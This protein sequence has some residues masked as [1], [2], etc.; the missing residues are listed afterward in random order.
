MSDGSTAVSTP[1]RREA[2]LIFFSYCRVEPDR[3]VAL[4]L[5]ELL[6]QQFDV[7]IDQN[8][9]PGADW[10]AEIETTIAGASCVIVLISEHSKRSPHVRAE[11]ELAHT[12]Y[13]EARRPAIIPVSVNF[14]G[15]PGYPLSAYVS[16][17]QFAAWK[18]P[19]DT[20][21]LAEELVKA[22]RRA[23]ERSKRKRPSAPAEGAQSRGL[24]AWLSGRRSS[25]N[26]TKLIR[27]VRRDW[28]E[29]FLY[30]ALYRV[31]RV[32]LDLSP[33]D[34]K[35]LR[36]VDLYLRRPEEP[37][38]LLA[39]AASVASIFSEQNGQLLILGAPGAGKTT[40]LLELT[41]DLLEAA[42]D[43][44]TVP[45]P[46]P[47]NLSS[48]AN[49]KKSLRD[50][51]AYELNHL[52]DCPGKLAIRW[53]RGEK[54]IPMLD[55]LD[56]V[57]EADREACVAAINEYRKEVG[58]EIVV[59][60]RVAEYDALT[61]RL[62]IPGAVVINLLTKSQVEQY[63][64]GGDERSKAVLAAAREDDTIWEV[65]DTPLTLD[66]AVL[67]SSTSEPWYLPS[68]TV[69]ER[70]AALFLRYID[71]MLE[72]RAVERRFQ[73]EQFQHWLGWL[74]FALIKRNQTQ[75][76][77]EDLT[78]DY[79][80][81][82]RQHRIATALATL[83]VGVPVAVSLKLLGYSGSSDWLGV[84]T[85]YAWLSASVAAA[86]GAVL[87]LMF[88]ICIAC[89]LALRVLQDAISGDSARFQR[90]VTGLILLFIGI[91]TAFAL[92]LGLGATAFN[93]LA[94]FLLF[95]QGS[96]VGTGAFCALL[97]WAGMTFGPWRPVD[98]VRWSWRKATEHFRLHACLVIA[99]GLLSTLILGWR[100][101]AQGVIFGAFMSLI[102]MMITGLTPG[103]L[104][105]KVRPN[106]GMR[107]SARNGAIAAVAGF[108]YGSALFAILFREPQWWSGGVIVAIVLGLLR[109]WAFCAQHW[110][111]RLVLWRSGVA[112]LRYTQF[113]DASAERI[114][115]HR[116]G[117][118]YI[119]VHRM[120]MNC[121]AAIYSAAT[122]EPMVLPSASQA[123]D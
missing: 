9:E 122:S 46:V 31:A 43:D 91:T 23:V 42:E 33:V 48:W 47:F 44:T 75:L 113:L 37:A 41:E 26:R 92:A 117:G 1:E 93:S 58:G 59:T 62:I 53:I 77:L 14:E 27:R 16:P 115:L 40:L 87:G 55:G 101:L 85:I 104:K 80:K 52:Y 18:G 63:L 89:A 25:K 3:S 7:F 2:P 112:P 99:L 49:S 88:A 24:F 100:G 97:V 90:T 94:A 74:A 105:E 81:T 64:E 71:R 35:A 72:W 61:T 28:I 106:E 95:G 120:L 60:S 68:G 21:R 8:L 57:P 11:V 116:V 83:G 73:R 119:F 78:R 29:G 5:S 70:R 121:F 50:W 45:V 15:H 66:V 19:E 76:R 65:L 67:G 51:L 30:R 10:G 108:L 103:E 12:R 98:E 38:Q 22:V 34:G 111:M 107:R 109:G 6:Q 39:S 79:L 96:W 114:F 123:K 13:R 32:E 20:E 4:R 84:A 17:F 110:S 102:V 86:F 118:G 69:E 82:K 56:E 36:P 54:I